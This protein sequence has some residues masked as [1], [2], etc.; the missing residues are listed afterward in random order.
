MSKIL[1]SGITGRLF[2]YEAGTRGEEKTEDNFLIIKI[3]KKIWFMESKT[4]KTIEKEKFEIIN[5]KSMNYNV[6]I[7][8]TFRISCLIFLLTISSRDYQKRFV[9]LK[10]IIQLF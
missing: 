1:R 7:I 4:H 3:M 6:K 2:I 10:N 9:L 8:E 5:Q